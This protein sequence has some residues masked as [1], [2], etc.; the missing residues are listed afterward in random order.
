[1]HVF[2]LE[3]LYYLDVVV[4]VELFEPIAIIGKSVGILGELQCKIVR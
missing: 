4:R 1:M 3:F 2:R